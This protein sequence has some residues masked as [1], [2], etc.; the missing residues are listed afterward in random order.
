VPYAMRV[1]WS[2]EFVHA[3][4]WST[5]DQG[6]DN[7]SHGC[8]GMSM[9]NAIWLFNQSTVGDIVKVVGSSRPLEPGNG[10]TDWNLSWSDWLAGSAVQS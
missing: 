3:A 1:T 8:V 7:V 2:G 10:Y 6:R 5:G 4:P 9:S